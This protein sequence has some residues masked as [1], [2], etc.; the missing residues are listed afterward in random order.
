MSQNPGRRFH[1]PAGSIAAINPLPISLRTKRALLF[2][3]GS[4]LLSRLRPFSLCAL[5]PRRIWKMTDAT[6]SFISA[7]RP[8]PDRT[9]AGPD[10]RHRRRQ[11]AGRR[12]VR[13]ASSIEAWIRC[14]TSGSG[15]NDVVRSR[16]VISSYARPSSSVSSAWMMSCS[17]FSLRACFGALTRS[18]FT[19]PTR[20]C[21]F[22]DAFTLL[23]RGRGTNR[24]S[25]SRW[26]D[27]HIP[28]I[29]RW[30]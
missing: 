4:R 23:A 30:E 8:V 18:S 29:R 27:I 13:R 2:S 5:A 22:G 6:G 21:A 17:R 7:Q 1:P 14:C 15:L 9:P 11:P 19:I 3:Q 24:S 26:E 25:L 16:I 12:R 20:S 28:S 10:R